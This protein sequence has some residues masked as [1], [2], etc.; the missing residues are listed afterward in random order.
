MENQLMP[1]DN[2]MRAREARTGPAKVPQTRSGEWG[3]GIFAAD[4]SI[5]SVRLRLLSIS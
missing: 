5:A 3:R 1:S 2:A 4:L